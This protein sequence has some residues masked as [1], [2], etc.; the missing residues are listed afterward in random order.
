MSHQNATKHFL[1]FGL[2]TDCE[3]MIFV[4]S[5]ITK[6]KSSQSVM[7]FLVLAAKAAHEVQLS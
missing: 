4:N 5:V 2:W 6:K 1:D 3:A 7:G